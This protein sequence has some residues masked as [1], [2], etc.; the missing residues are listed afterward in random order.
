MGRVLITGATGFIGSHVTRIFCEAGIETGCLVRETSNLSNIKNLPVELRY[1]EIEDLKSLVN[2][3]K[4]FDFIIHIAAY[5]HDWG[6]YET[7]YKVN[8]EGTLNVLQ[9]CYENQVGNIIIT[10][11]N[12]VYGET[13]CS[14]VKDENSP[15]DSHYLYWGDKIFPSRL[16]YYRDTKT[17]AKKKAIEY[18]KA[19]K[20]NLTIL[21]PVWVYGEREFHTIF[22][23]YLKVAKSALPYL[24]G[25]RKNK[26][27]VIYAEDLARAYLLA[28]Q[29][30]LPGIEC[31]II[32]NEKAESMDKICSLLCRE[33]GI[34]KP[35]NLPK[36]LSYPIGFIWELLYTVFNIKTPPML[37]RGRVNMFYDNIEYSTVKAKKLL[38][39][40]NSYTLEE[41]IRK[42]V[43]WYKDRKL[44]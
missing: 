17:T 20:L 36:Y 25:C 16:N 33:A 19:N 43:A 3:F 14:R 12:S 35:R 32:G 39:F 41:G 40:T 29:K 8:V 23:S 9:A 6:K 1:G 38:G 34:K 21:E 13:D 24:P 42:T 5:V 4:N 2:A 28:F 31:I 26:F 22:F 11:S 37:T 30:K 44:I 7:F 10:G 27:H 18:A 15:G